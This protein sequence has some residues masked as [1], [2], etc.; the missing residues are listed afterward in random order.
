MQIFRKVASGRPLVRLS[1]RQVAAARS[2]PTTRETYDARSSGSG[3]KRLRGVRVRD[4]EGA[5]RENSYQRE[6]RGAY[7]PVA[8][9]SRRGEKAP[10]TRLWRD[11][12]I[13]GSAETGWRV[14]RHWRSFLSDRL[15]VRFQRAAGSFQPQHSLEPKLRWPGVKRLNAAASPASTSTQVA[16]R[17]PVLAP[18]SNGGGPSISHRLTVPKY[19]GEVRTSAMQDGR[20]DSRAGTHPAPEPRSIAAAGAARMYKKISV[21]VRL[22][23]IARV[24]SR[25][26]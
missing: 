2:T 5:D 18:G 3:E 16:R 6:T 7:V 26:R 19:T 24:R 15:P 8:G 11:V 4:S 13:G 1:H 14:Q 21:G 9:I 23:S 12:V 10:A 20:I 22:S 25:S 17:E